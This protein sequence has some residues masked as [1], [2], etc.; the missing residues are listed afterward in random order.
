MI[1]RARAP[2]R[3]SFGGG[4]TDV[5]PYSER[6]GG[7]VLSAT[8]DKY[9]YCSVTDGVGAAYSLRSADMGL[10]EI[11]PDLKSLQYNGKLDLAKAVIKTVC[12]PSDKKLDLSI[13]SEAPP[14]SGLGASS[15]L[16][17]SIIKAVSDF[18]GLPAS[19]YSIAELAFRLE[20]IELN[21]KGGYQDQ[22]AA[23]FG[24]F[25]FIEFGNKIVTVNPLRIKEDILRELLASLV[26]V[27]TG[28]RRLSSD[29]LARQIRSY[30]E[31]DGEVMENLQRLKDVTYEMKASLL[32]GEL[33]RFGELLGKEWGFKKRL[34]K[35][36][37]NSQI[38]SLYRNALQNGAAG[39]K[40][41]GAGD[42][43][44][45]LFF[46]D[47]WKKRDLVRY[48]ASAGWTPIAFNFDDKGVVSWKLGEDGVLA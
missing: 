25:N 30:E 45:M 29:I 17:V 36:I 3:I 44:H 1:V 12:G 11:Y 38:E 37:S 47:F 19:S 18:L 14:G 27:D 39:G 28:K 13:L 16:M 20:R 10:H 5:P 23:A 24:G 15:A 46:V 48:L 32:R 40:V 6:H 42:G 43:G 31:E 8:I 2:L 21:I 41:L 34:D 22:Y 4:G 26:L 7:V 35:M 33:V 9:A